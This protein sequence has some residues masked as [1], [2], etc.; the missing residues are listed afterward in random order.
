MKIGFLGAHLLLD[1][2]NERYMILRHG[3][4]LEI[5]TPFNNVDIPKSFKVVITGIL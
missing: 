2:E 5:N 3:G 1:I 4:S